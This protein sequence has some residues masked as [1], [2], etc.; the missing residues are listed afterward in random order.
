MCISSNSELP[1]SADVNPELPIQHQLD[2]IRTEYHPHANRP[3][4]IVSFENFIRGPSET[5]FA[6]YTHSPWLPFASRGDFEFAD[7][8]HDAALNQ[9]QINTLLKLIHR[10]IDRTETLSFT[11]YSQLETKWAEASP[12][13]TTV[14][15]CDPMPV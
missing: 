5:E 13:V 1:A 9:T 4:A 14:I 3:P 12:L 10:Y 7:F 6:P 2:D 15:P 11:T 8:A